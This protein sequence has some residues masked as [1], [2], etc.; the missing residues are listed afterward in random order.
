MP[1]A[2]LVSI[3]SRLCFTDAG[4]NPS[5]T[6][7]DCSVAVAHAGLLTA[8][9]SHP[10]RPIPIDADSIDLQERAE[11]LDALFG[12]LA[13]YLAIV[14]DGTAQN[15][16]GGLDLTDAEAILADLAADLTGAIEHAADEMVGRVE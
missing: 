1:R 10:P 14:L 5:T 3:A 12:G 15:V 7:V 13:A 2:K 16:P 8:L 4:A 11:H 6:A 9:A